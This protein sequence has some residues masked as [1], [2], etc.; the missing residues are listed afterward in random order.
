MKLPK[1]FFS[2]G[3]RKPLEPSRA[4]GKLRVNYPAAKK[5][6][7]WDNFTQNLLENP[8]MPRDGRG[9]NPIRGLVLNGLKETT[10]E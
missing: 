2:Q 4:S 9:L 8:K 3:P 5:R 1:L 7:G 6:A 10:S